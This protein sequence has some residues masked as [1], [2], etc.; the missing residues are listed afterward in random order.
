MDDSSAIQSAIVGLRAANAQK[1][2]VHLQAITLGSLDIYFRACVVSLTL[3][4]WRPALRNLM[5]ARVCALL[6]LCSALGL[7]WMLEQP[8]SSLFEHLPWFVW[9]TKQYDIYKVP[10]KHWSSVSFTVSRHLQKYLYRNI[11]NFNPMLF[12][13]LAAGIPL[14]GSLRWYER[15]GLSLK[16]SKAIW[17]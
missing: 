4:V 12:E 8:Q 6:Y 15:S 2:H 13:H 11:S 5:G 9:L 17:I 1:A 16:L 3:F 7:P 14:D 10:G